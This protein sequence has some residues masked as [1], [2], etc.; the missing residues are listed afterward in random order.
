[1]G[2]EWVGTQWLGCRIEVEGA[3]SEDAGVEKVVC[4]IGLYAAAAAAAAKATA[5]S[6]G[7]ALVQSDRALVQHGMGRMY[8]YERALVESGR[9]A[10]DSME[11]CKRGVQRWK[12]ARRRGHWVTCVLIICYL[13]Y[14]GY[15]GNGA[16]RLVSSPRGHT[17]LFDVGGFRA[18][19]QNMLD[20]THDEQESLRRSG[21]PRCSP[22]RWPISRLSP[23]S[24]GR[25]TWLHDLSALLSSF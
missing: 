19:C 16:M 22:H 1:V 2:W 15:L 18:S 17:N 20:L 13:G 25:R 5:G 24:L 12:A 11:G 3:E 7:K 9:V 10:S 23:R 4:R 6:A 8:M 14:L 21:E